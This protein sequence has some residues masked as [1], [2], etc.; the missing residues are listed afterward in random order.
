[1]AAQRGAPIQ[2]IT[3]LQIQGDCG[4]LTL[5]TRTMG[6][7]VWFPRTTPK[8]PP[9]PRQKIQRYRLSL[10]AFDWRALT[11]EEKN[12]W[13]L[14]ATVPRTWMSG[15]NLFTLMELNT[16]AS[17]FLTTLAHVAGLEIIPPFRHR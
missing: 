1:M 9:S 10:V 3:N 13:H 4:P 17:R 7:V 15:Y 2:A 12:L 8:E 16:E 11:R 6:R 5:Y 14:L